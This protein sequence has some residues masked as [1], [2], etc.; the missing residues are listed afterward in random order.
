M[1]RNNPAN[2]NVFDDGRTLPVFSGTYPTYTLIMLPDRDIELVLVKFE[3]VASATVANRYALITFE[4]SAH[5][6]T[7]GHSTFP[8]TAGERWY[9]TLAQGLQDAGTA[10]GFYVTAP[11][12]QRLRLGLNPEVRLTILNGHV[13]DRIYNALVRTNLQLKTPQ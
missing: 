13:D 8:M 10:D 12:C 6:Q 4:S 1:T 3:L 11:L 7:L 2:W 5:L 9:V